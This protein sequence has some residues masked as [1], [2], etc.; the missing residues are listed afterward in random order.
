MRFVQRTNNEISPL[1][2]Y[3]FSI[4]LPKNLLLHLTI[5]IIF[6]NQQSI[7]EILLLTI[8]G[9]QYD[10]KFILTLPLTKKAKF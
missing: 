1:Q 8:D 7:E 4:L 10:K 5:Y 6:V 2:E 3:C 9:D